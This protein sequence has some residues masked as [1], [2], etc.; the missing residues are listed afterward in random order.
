MLG[1]TV[2]RPLPLSNITPAALY[3]SIEAWQPT[4]LIDEADTFLQKREELRGILNAGH[5]K[6]TAYVIRSVGE[7]Y[8]PRLFSTWAPKAVAMIGK[9]PPTLAD[10]AIMLPMRRKLPSEKVERLRQGHMEGFN[11]LQRRC[12][13]WAQDHMERLKEADP[14]LPEGLHDRAADNWRPL[15]AI[16]EIAGPAWVKRAHAAIQALSWSDASD[17]AASAQLLK[18]IREVFHNGQNNKIFSADLLQELHH[19]ELRPWSDWYHGKA[20]TPRQVARLLEPYGIRPNTIR[21][22]Q[23]V[24]KGYEQAQFQDAFARY[25]PSLAVTLLQPSND[26]DFRQNRA[27]TGAVTACPYVTEE[28]HA[29]TDEVTDEKARKPTPDKDCNVVTAPQGREESVR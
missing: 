22:G 29:V 4:L 17:D 27:V 6:P 25:L 18:D 10:R 8:E 11:D 15:C 26:A 7:D 16:A 13:R 12:I 19:L 1:G 24:K 21:I 2:R 14:T 28:H 5:T 9:L 3:R 23:E 20:I